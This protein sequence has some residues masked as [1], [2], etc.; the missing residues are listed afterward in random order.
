LRYGRKILFRTASGVIN[1]GF[2]HAGNLAYLSLLTLFPFIIVTAALARLLGQNEDTEHAVDSVLSTLPP[3][4][5]DMLEQPI[6][7]VLHART[8]S[9]LWL[10]AMVGLWTVGSFIETIR[11]ILR[12]A[13]GT[14]SSRPFWQHRL[15]SVAIIIISIM[16]MMAGFAAQVLLTA[17]EQFV[18]Q[19]FPMAHEISSWLRVTRLVPAAIVFGALY[20][21]FWSLTPGRYRTRWAPKWPGALFVMLWW[22]G[23]LQLLPMVLQRLHGYTLTYGGLAGFVIALLFFWL[24]GYGLVIG[25]H[26]NAALAE[27]PLTALRASGSAM[28]P[29]MPTHLEDE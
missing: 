10:G 8:G 23:V 4:V 18:G 25:A 13:Y 11:D 1:D 3:Q 19:L 14:T 21:M 6:N 27:P 24:I 26:L 29:T 5:G 22:Y 9:L 7:D 12:R 28:G 20:L 2:I 15:R 16:L 17:V